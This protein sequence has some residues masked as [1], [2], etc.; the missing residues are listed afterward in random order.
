MN[1]NSARSK[2]KYFIRVCLQSGTMNSPLGDEELAV[3]C[4]CDDEAPSIDNVDIKGLVKWVN[5]NPSC[6]KNQSNDNYKLSKQEG[7]ITTVFLSVR[8]IICCNKSDRIYPRLATSLE[9]V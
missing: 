6:M 3:F 4:Q 5:S 7:A 8:E 2:G 9:T 1:T